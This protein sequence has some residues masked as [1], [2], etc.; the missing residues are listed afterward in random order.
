[1]ARSHYIYAVEE[2]SLNTYWDVVATFTVKYECIKF[3]L[4]A[5]KKEPDEALIRIKRFR[6]GPY[7]LQETLSFKEFVYGKASK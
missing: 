2:Y 1:M 7:G 5:I 3:L 6:D 4:E